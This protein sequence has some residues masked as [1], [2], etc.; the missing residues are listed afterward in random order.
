MARVVQGGD[1]TTVTVAG[2]GSCAETHEWVASSHA[3]GSLAATNCSASVAGEAWF[4]LATT[5]AARASFAKNGTAW[6]TPFFDS[7]TQ[8]PSVAVVMQAANTTGTGVMLLCVC[9]SRRG[10]ASDTAT[11][12]GAEQ[13][14]SVSVPLEQLSRVLHDSVSAYEEAAFQGARGY[15]VASDYRV[16]AAWD[17]GR[18]TAWQG[19]HLRDIG[20]CERWTRLSRG[21]TLCCLSAGIARGCNHKGGVC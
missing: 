6:T 4:E 14:V 1:A 16:V 5:A 19:Q 8:K 13:V 10:S 2:A 18:H 21:L 11:N 12:T 15:I 20:G 9:V 17:E 7:F 3:R